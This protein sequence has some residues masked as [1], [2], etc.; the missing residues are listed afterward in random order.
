MDSRRRA[1]TYNFRHKGLK[2]PGLGGGGTSV[3]LLK[4]WRQEDGKFQDSL[5]YIARPHLT[6]VKKQNKRT[7]WADT[8]AKI[9]GFWFLW[10]LPSVP[11]AFTRR[12]A[13]WESKAHFLKTKYPK[14]QSPG[15][16]YLGKNMPRP[17][18]ASWIWMSTWLHEELSIPQ[19]MSSIRKA[20]YLLTGK[21]EGRHWGP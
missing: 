16:K 18:R 9:F 13:W 1:I 5:G 20:V 12:S 6:K 2:E 14:W 15:Q 21:P 4:G 3:L 8:S 11:A 19:R 17:I 10:L 7:E